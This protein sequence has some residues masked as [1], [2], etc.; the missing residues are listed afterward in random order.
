MEAKFYGLARLDLRR[1]IYQLPRRNNI[2]HPFGKG[3]HGALAG[4]A[5]LN[6]FLKRH[7]DLSIGLRGKTQIASLISAEREALWSIIMYINASGHLL[8]PM[9]IYPTKNMIMHLMR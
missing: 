6:L 5:W 9:V 4:R 3:G 8:P 7:K 2:Q 1:M